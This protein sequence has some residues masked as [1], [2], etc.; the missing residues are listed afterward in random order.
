M[1]ERSSGFH[2]ALSSQI[3]YWKN[4]KLEIERRSAP[5]SSA[6]RADFPFVTVSREYGCGGYELAE[7]LADRLNAISLRKAPWM[8]YDR[9]LLEQ[10]ASDL[11]LSHALTET[12]TTKARKQ[13]AS[14]FETTFSVYPSQV[15]VYRKL[16]EIVRTLATNGH[17]ILV[18]RGSNI[19][20][21]DMPLG[22]HVRLVASMDWKI[23]RIA[24]LMNL[25][26]KDAEKLIIE[27]NRNREGF[28]AEFA[29]FDMS[30]PNN[31]HMVINN[32]RFTV[33]QTADIIVAALTPMV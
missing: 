16:T 29:R 14:F 19:I 4:Q 20:T 30:D 1:K 21:R 15:T 17:V 31:Y 24:S 25:K 11:G 22:F 33:G 26:K 32:E 3:N 8:A 23:D 18:G 7:I 9:K 28:F 2:T 6:P 13:V 10:I 12:L 27:K 5:E